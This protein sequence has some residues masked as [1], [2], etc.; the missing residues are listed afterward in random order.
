MSKSN[1]TN[2]QDLQMQNLQYDR[3]MVK[4]YLNKVCDGVLT[5][6]D[7]NK[8]QFQFVEQ[9]QVQK[10]ILV[11]CKC[12]NF[13][14]VPCNITKFEASNCSIES[15][16]GIQQMTGLQ[17]LNLSSNLISDISELKFMVKLQKLFL[18]SNKLTHLHPLSSL[19]SLQQLD[20]RKNDIFD[21]NG[22][23]N[24]S[25]TNLNLQ[26]NKICELSALS[27]LQSLEVLNLSQ[28][29]IVSVL[30]LKFCRIRSLDVSKNLITDITDLNQC[31]YF[32]DYI[33]SNQKVPTLFQIAFSNRVQ[34]INSSSTQI[35]Q[36]KRAYH[37]IRSIKTN[38]KKHIRER[39]EF[40]AETHINYLKRINV[41]ITEEVT[42]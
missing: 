20:A 36:I 31:I 24:L 29:L 2:K 34:S 32:K 22:L 35:N 19:Y 16:T 21:I 18:S 13:T 1:K 12:I 5:I 17:Q 3:E 14:K 38:L 6:Y 9:L 28:N 39:V 10:L 33:R 37:K 27:T 42:Q 25:I 26:C 23:M 15:I 11:K 30:P 4:K 41:L 8:L 40:G 7:A